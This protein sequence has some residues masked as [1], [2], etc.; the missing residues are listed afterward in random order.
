MCEIDDYHPDSLSHVPTLIYRISRY[1]EKKRCQI[2][3]QYPKQPPGRS[4]KK[5]RPKESLKYSWTCGVKEQWCRIFRFLYHYNGM[6]HNSTTIC[7]N[8]YS[9]NKKTA[10]DT[11][12][13]AFKNASP[14]HWSS[15]NPPSP[16][17]SNHV[18]ST[19]AWRGNACGGGG[20]IVTAAVLNPFSS[21]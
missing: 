20:S 19:Q 1:F 6:E 5:K 16:D 15:I 2:H 10:V 4:L 12:Y 8:N 13:F 21:C 9:D 3:Y 11:S 18:Y 14:M 7:N 17:L